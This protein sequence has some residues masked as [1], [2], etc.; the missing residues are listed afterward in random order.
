[1]QEIKMKIPLNKIFVG[2]ADTFILRGKDL[3]GY[4]HTSPPETLTVI[5]I[6]TDVQFHNIGR[7]YD[8]EGFTDHYASRH[9]SKIL[10]ELD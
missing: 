8:S 5:G 4:S 7:S 10:I 1:M 6:F 3:P 2:N 9:G